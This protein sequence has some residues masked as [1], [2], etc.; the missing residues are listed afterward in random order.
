MNILTEDI[1]FSNTKLT[2]TNQRVIY[3]ETKE[4]LILS[5]IH[6]G[7]T[8]HFRQH[9]IAVADTILHEDLERLSTLITH[10]SPKRIIVVG[11]LF[12]A[13]YNSNIEIFKD[14]LI[15]ISHIDKVLIK[16]NHDKMSEK[17]IQKLGF[18]TV[19]FLRENGLTFRHDLDDAVEGESIICG[20]M[21]PGVRIKFKGN[22]Y[23]KLPCYLVSKHQL[24]LPAFSL[25]TGLNT[26]FNQEENKA[27]AFDEQLIFRV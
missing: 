1:E 6:I 25:F 17:K 8:A 10:F 18:E 27:Y 12:H 26:K 19:S 21:H 15:S 23:I 11:D 7:K 14:W 24:I 4:T 22:Q 13:N 3:W 20:H 5:D 16:G 9:G 2:L